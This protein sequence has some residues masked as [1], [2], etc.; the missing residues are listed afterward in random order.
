MLRAAL[1]A[2]AAQGLAVEAASPILASAPV[3]PSLRRYANGV[4][5]IRTPLAPPELLQQLKTMERAFGRR[6][7]GQRWTARVLDLDI[8]LWDGGCWRS[9]GLAIP[10]PAFRQR[11]FVLAPALAIAGGWID[12]GSGLSLRQLHA[13]LLCPRPAASSG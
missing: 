5:I 10:H 1:A 4:A 9:P 8:V 3:G 13:R 2:L 11:S 6:P 12:P 7:G